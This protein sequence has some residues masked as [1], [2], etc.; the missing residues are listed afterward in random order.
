MVTE[1]LIKN[2]EKKL[3]IIFSKKI[4]LYIFAIR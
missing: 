2:I 4:K 3:K 1:V